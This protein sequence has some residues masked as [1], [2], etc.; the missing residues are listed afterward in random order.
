MKLILLFA[1]S[2]AFT[3][4]VWADEAE[5]IAKIAGILEAQGVSQQISLQLDQLRG[6]SFHRLAKRLFDKAIADRPAIAG[7]DKKDVVEILMRFTQRGASMLTA[8]DLVRVAAHEYGKDLSDTD[9]DAIMTYYQSPAGKK[10]VS[11]TLRVA[12]MLPESIYRT[13]DEK[14]A[15][16][17]AIMEAELDGLL[18]Q[19]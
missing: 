10:D 14:L 17:V 18:K 1:T 13:F 7:V 19:R 11:A 16:S 6:E 15:E 5:R 2:L 3:T 4:Q 12:G 9:L 8:E